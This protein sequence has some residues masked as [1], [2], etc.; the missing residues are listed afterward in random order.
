MKF[1]QVFPAKTLPKTP[2]ISG[3]FLLLTHAHF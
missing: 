2:E 3:A 1:S